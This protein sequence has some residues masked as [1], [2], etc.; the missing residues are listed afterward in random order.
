MDKCETECDKK[1]ANCKDNK[2]KIDGIIKE[3]VKFKDAQIVINTKCKDKMEIV[4]TMP[5]MKRDLYITMGTV[6]VIL[7]LL[8]INLKANAD[9]TK[10]IND[11]KSSNTEINLHIE[12]EKGLESRRE[13]QDREITIMQTD[14]KYLKQKTDKIDNKMDLILER[15]PKK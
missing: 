6:V 9:I 12:K 1:C 10:E 13:R 3:F 15:L 2:E 5:G 4:N 14:I 8:F 11:M 7:S